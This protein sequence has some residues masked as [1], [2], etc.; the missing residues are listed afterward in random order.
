MP[1]AAGRNDNRGGGGRKENGI[2][3]F[4]AV[5]CTRFAS[6]IGLGLCRGDW[7]ALSG[8]PRPGARMLRLRGKGR[9]SRPAHPCSGFLGL[10][11]C[12]GKIAKPGAP[13]TLV[14][15]FAGDWWVLSGFPRPGARM[16]RLLRSVQVRRDQKRRRPCWLV[17]L[18]QPRPRKRRSQP[19]R[20][21]SSRSFTTKAK[22]RRVPLGGRPPRTG[23]GMAAS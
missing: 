4:P 11:K 7:R 22:R 6:Y 21:L 15:G 13:P 10:C 1:A 20:S 19:S 17:S 18:R 3:G 2:L 8:F 9:P 12:A 16:L 5:C 23:Q 14:W